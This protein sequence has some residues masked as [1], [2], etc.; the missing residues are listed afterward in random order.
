MV[1]VKYNFAA[2]VAAV[3]PGICALVVSAFEDK[4]R[5]KLNGIIQEVYKEMKEE[6]P[7]RIKAT[8]LGV[9][10]PETLGPDINIIIDL[11]NKKE[12]K[13]AKR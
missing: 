2:L 11:T 7:T 9:L 1:T 6:L 10:R 13:G 12:R 5:E 3:E 8:V 4:L